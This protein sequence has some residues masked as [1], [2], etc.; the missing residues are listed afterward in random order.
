[1]KLNELK[2]LAEQGKLKLEKR[3]YR[4]IIRR[5]F[6]W[7]NNWQNIIDIKKINYKIFNYM[8]STKDMGNT[9]WKITK[10]DYIEL[11]KICGSKQTTKN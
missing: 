3:F 1:M 7:D 8:A 2:T 9:F 6:I 10:K 4:N 11:E 5:K